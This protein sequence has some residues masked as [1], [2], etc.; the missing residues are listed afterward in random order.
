MDKKMENPFDKSPYSVVDDASMQKLNKEAA[1]R[2]VVLLKNEDNLL[3]LKKS[4]I[5]T[6]AV[7]GPNGNSRKALLGNY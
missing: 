2:C 7:I 5:R 1:S 6:I 4:D 3:P